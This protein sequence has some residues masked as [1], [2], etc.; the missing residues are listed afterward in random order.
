[1]RGRARS[2]ASGRCAASTS[3]QPS[4]TTAR[5]PRPEASDDLPYRPRSGRALRRARAD[6]GG[7]RAAVLDA[8]AGQRLDRRKRRRHL[9][10]GG[11]E[12]GN[13][14]ELEAATTI[15]RLDAT[16]ATQEFVAPSGQFAS[17]A[18]IVL[19][20]D[21]NVWYTRNGGTDGTFG[22]RGAV[23]GRMT[24]AGEFVEFQGPVGER[25]G[26]I[27]V[28]A[29]GNLWFAEP[30]RGG[31]GRVT[32]AGV[33]LLP[34]GAPRSPSFAAPTATSGSPTRRMPRRSAASRRREPSAG[35]TSTRR[36]PARSSRA[37][38]RRRGGSGRRGR[39]DPAR[40]ALVPTAR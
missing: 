25:I 26:G 16:G 19:G 31:I 39:Q 34:P 6:R 5:R 23:V 11:D 14:S 18:D 40:G 13:L 33:Q 21:G 15:G 8:D 10:R 2:V 29:D 28:G 1:M 20:P 36:P 24:P 37:P 12:S 22:A 9:V 27:A 7:G 4:R 32:T 35:S 17:I 38:T 30:Q 3:L